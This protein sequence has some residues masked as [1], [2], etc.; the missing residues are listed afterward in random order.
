MATMF[1]HFSD[2]RLADLLDRLA[3]EFAEQIDPNDRE[4]NDRSEHLL[5]E[6]GRRLRAGGGNATV[7]DVVSGG[8]IIVT[9]TSTR[10]A[11]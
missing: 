6:A 8:D 9:A 1:A 11:R 5:I 4:A 3:T 2:D 7:S 10:W